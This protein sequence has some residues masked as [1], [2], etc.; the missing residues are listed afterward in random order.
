MN[1]SIRDQIREKYRPYSG[2][3]TPDAILRLCDEHEQMERLLI[4]ISKMMEGE[5]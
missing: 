4:T 3:E 5:K 2:L 1:N